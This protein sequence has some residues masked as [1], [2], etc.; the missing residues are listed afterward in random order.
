MN[1]LVIPYLYRTVHFHCPGRIEFQDNVLQ[2]LE[3]F[4]DPRFSG[5]L[6]TTHVFVTGSWYDTYKEVE[7]DLSPHC[8]LS[9]A[10][11]MFNSLISSCVVR[12]PHLKVFM[13]VLPEIIFNKPLTCPSQLGYADFPD[14]GIVDFHNG[15][16]KS[17]IYTAA[18]G[19]QLHP[20]AVFPSNPRIP[21]TSQCQGHAVRPGQ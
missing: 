1:H 4:A 20:Q 11:R 7:S 2:K 6:H 14:P 13:Y 5:L 3:L 12:M 8:L 17:R 16:A 15:A 19:H 21:P 10:V 9:P 18:T